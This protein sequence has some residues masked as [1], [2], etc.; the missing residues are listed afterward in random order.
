LLRFYLLHVLAVPA[1]L[2]IFTGVH[3]YKVIIHGHSLPPQKENIGED[4]AKRVPLDKRVY[5]IPDVLTSE[6]MWIG[7]TSFILVVLC[8]WFFHAPLENHADPQHTPLGTTAPWYF[9]WIQGALKLGDKVLWGIIFPT[10]V[11][12]FLMIWPYIDTTISRRYADRRFALSLVF[13]LMSATT[14]LS[15][16][17]LAEYGVA[18]SADSDIVYEMTH[19][20]A[21]NKMGI[22]LPVPYEQLVPGMYTTAQFAAEEGE[23]A[24]VL[25]AFNERIGEEEWNTELTAD[26]N[27]SYIN[28][29]LPLDGSGVRFRPVPDDA[30]ELA[31]VMERFHELMEENDQELHNGWGAVVISENQENLRR[32]D[33]VVAWEEVLIEGNRPVIGEDGNIIPLFETA[34]YNLDENEARLVD[35]EGRALDEEGNVLVDAEGRLVDADGNLLMVDEAGLPVLNDA[36]EVLIAEEGVDG[37]LVAVPVFRIT[38]DHIFVH[39]EAAYFQ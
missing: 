21:H 6:L 25:A 38:E 2:F 26:L 39:R 4:T 5:F 19:E 37:A 27:E 22:L 24:E 18:T 36:G 14:V 7:T 16:M 3:Y 9:L 17:G 32:V 1:L 34:S 28:P 33:V 13:V 10:I 8:I 15:Y 35:A 23:E 20:P 11:F 12:V 31:A 30:P 29:P